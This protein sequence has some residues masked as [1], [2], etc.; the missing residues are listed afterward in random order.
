MKF[1]YFRLKDYQVPFPSK[2]DVVQQRINNINN[3]SD[4]RLTRIIFKGVTLMAGPAMKGATDPQTWQKMDQQRFW[5]TYNMDS[6]G[7]VISTEVSFPLFTSQPYK[8]LWTNAAAKLLTMSNFEG[9]KNW[10]V[11]PVDAGMQTYSGFFGSGDWGSGVVGAAAIYMFVKKYSDRNSIVLNGYVDKGTITRFIDEVAPLNPTTP[12]AGK[13]G[14]TTT[15]NELGDKAKREYVKSRV[16]AVEG[17]RVTDAGKQYRFFDQEGDGIYSEATA[18]GGRRATVNIN[19]TGGTAS[20]NVKFVGESGFEQLLSV[21]APEIE[22]TVNAAFKN[23]FGKDPGGVGMAFTLDR[24]ALMEVARTNRA[25]ADRPGIFLKLLDSEVNRQIKV[26]TGTIAGYDGTTVTAYAYSVL[27]KS[28]VELSN[29]SESM[30]KRSDKMEK[31]LR[32][33]LA[34]KYKTLGPGESILATDIEEMR[35]R[36]IWNVLSESEKRPYGGAK[37]GDEAFVTFKKAVQ[38]IGLDLSEEV[39]ISRGIRIPFSR[40]KRIPLPLP[41]FMENFLEKPNVRKVVYNAKG[42]AWG[43]LWCAVVLYGGNWLKNDVISPTWDWALHRNDV[44]TKKV[45]APNNT[46]PGSLLTAELSEQEVAVLKNAHIFK[47]PVQDYS[48]NA[49]AVNEQSPPDYFVPGKAADG[50]NTFSVN[51]EFKIDNTSAPGSAWAVVVAYKTN[52]ADYTKFF[53][54]PG[55]E[56]SDGIVKVGAYGPTPAYDAAGKAVEAGPGTYKLG[57]YNIN[58]KAG[59]YDILVEKLDENTNQYKIFYQHAGTPIEP[60]AMKGAAENGVASTNNY[61]AGK[62]YLHPLGK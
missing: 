43:A 26:Y 45:D 28:Y 36:A 31:E 47:A 32:K 24:D 38:E 54:L 27:P 30:V 46:A 20:G 61:V 19:I 53:G 55:V 21:R 18:T 29:L 56:I 11:S 51:G 12:L 22:E 42:Y 15:L 7:K 60:L 1:K 35:I 10:L 39:K 59:T 3:A 44:I 37:G 8:D 48:R 23:A 50:A 2:E 34:E 5:V 41:E 49:V 58:F 57:I 9:L 40:G 17:V 25:S 52:P 13:D 6:A 62:F 16:D 33:L 14:A 4:S